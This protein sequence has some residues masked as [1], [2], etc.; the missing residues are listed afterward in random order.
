MKDRKRRLCDEEEKEYS[1]QRQRNLSR[2]ELRI[3]EP[4]RRK[5]E[6]TQSGQRSGMEVG[7]R[8]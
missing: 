2:K 3:V 4:Q 7:N 6:K 8:S 5:E 1:R